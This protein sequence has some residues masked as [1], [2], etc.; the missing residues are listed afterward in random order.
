MKKVVSII[1]A[2]ILV[3]SIG[4]VAFAS[5]FTPS[6]TEK[7]APEIVRPENSVEEDTVA[8]IITTDGEVVKEIPGQKLVVTGVAHVD[9]SEEIPEESAADL[10]EAYAQ[11]SAED[12]KLV[13]VLPELEEIVKENLGEEKTV[14]DLVVRDLFDVSLV[15]EES[16]ELLL[17]EEHRLSLTFNLGV[18]ANEFVTAMKMNPLTKE[19]ETIYSVKNNGDGTVT[20]EFDHL[21][22]IAFLVEAVKSSEP[23]G[24][25]EVEPEDTDKPEDTEKPGDSA[26]TGDN[27]VSLYVWVAIAVAAAGLIV[28]LLVAKNKK[29]AE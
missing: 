16:N 15:C 11:L 26:Q 20:C 24:D 22:P 2:V 13:E 10:K 18:K 14:E 8:H 28:V 17:D 5:N 27:S 23:S 21:C 7:P 19:W 12:V 9:I 3:F 1:L 4:T 6:V 29:A 25:I